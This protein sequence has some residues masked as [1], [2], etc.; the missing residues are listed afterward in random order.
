MPR[1]ETGWGGLYRQPP[2]FYW[3]LAETEDAAADLWALREKLLPLAR[4]L[5]GGRLAD[6]EDLLNTALLRA[7]EARSRSMLPEQAA[8]PWLVRV[9]RNLAA[10][11]HRRRQTASRAAVDPTFLPASA[12][13]APDAAL[14][15]RADDAMFRRALAALAPHHRSAYGLRVQDGLSYAEVAA[16]LRVS[17]PTARKRVQLARERLAAALRSLMSDA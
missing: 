9:L 17:E 3:P 7:L 12:G 10:D 1:V 15:R 2:P 11:A 4:R 16:R 13:P 14:L 6:A 5:A 8:L